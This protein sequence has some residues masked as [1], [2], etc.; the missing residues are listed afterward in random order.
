MAPE[1]TLRLTNHSGAPLRY[2][3]WQYN[4]LPS[5]SQGYPVDTGTPNPIRPYLISSGTLAKDPR[6]LTLPGSSRDTGNRRLPFAAG[7]RLYV[8]QAPLHSLT[9]PTNPTAPDPFGGSDAGGSTPYSFWEFTNDA[10][11]FSFNNSYINE[12][13]FPIQL[14]SG[15]R[16]YGFDSLDAVKQQLI[17]QASFVAAGQGTNPRAAGRPGDLIWPGG[18]RILGPLS[19]WQVQQGGFPPTTPAGI[20]RFVQ[21]V[22]FN[23]T[24][25]NTTGESNLNVWNG[26]LPPGLPSPVDGTPEPNG[27]TTALRNAARSAGG[28][29]PQPNGAEPNWQGFYTY[30]QENLYGGTQLPLIPPR[31]AGAPATIDLGLIVHGLS[32]SS[33]L[34]G[35]GRRDRLQ[36]SPRADVITGGVG[37]DRL[38]GGG[39]RD[40]FLYLSA[41]SSPVGRRSSD[42][43]TDFDLRR[44]RI[45]LSGMPDAEPLPFRRFRLLSPGGHAGESS[46]SGQA[47]E[48]LF[49][50]TRIDPGSS[51]LLGDLNGDGRA[52]FRVR[53]AGV[54]LAA[55]AAS[56]AAGGNRPAFLVL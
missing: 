43:I 32:S 26:G 51:K 18:N 1:V 25:L 7:V 56:F 10:R 21:A 16:T 46:F 24:D 14:R 20:R 8:S 30:P 13:S 29:G 39:G 2:Y 36:G 12:W 15:G 55:I 45:D 38:S 27:Y 42:V 41:A 40:R 11:G 52:E 33:A 47:G 9:D 44:D 50:Q 19:A 53:L 49:R 22:P 48:L 34:T 4:T 23:G 6:S 5:G 35:T 17:S 3:I 54:S 37:A 28:I 31:K